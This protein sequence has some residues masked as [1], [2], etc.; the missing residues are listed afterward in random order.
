MLVLCRN[1]T[2]AVVKNKV[3]VDVRVTA[4]MCGVQDRV[5]TESGQTMY[6]AEEM[7]TSACS[8]SIMV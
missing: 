2:A 3:A 4:A 5:R 7:G 8:T 6:W 1:R